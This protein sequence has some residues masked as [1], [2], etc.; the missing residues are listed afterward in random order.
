MKIQPSKFEDLIIGS[1]EQF[2]NWAA[3][4]LSKQREAP[5]SCTVWKAFIGRNRAS[6]ENRNGKDCFSNATLLQ[7]RWGLLSG[8]L[9]QFSLGA[10]M[11][12]TFMTDYLT[13]TDQKIADGLLTT[14]LHA[15]GHCS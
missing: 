5:R 13:G 15:G 8:R 10:G 2:V 3:S 4:H 9:P 1:I 12:R 14:T 6:R 11:E 7:G